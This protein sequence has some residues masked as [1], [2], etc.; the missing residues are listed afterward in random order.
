VARRDLLQALGPFDERLHIYG[1]DIDLCLR[2]HRAGAETLSAP[3]VAQVVHLGHRSAGRRYQDFGQRTKITT[4]GWVIREHF[5]GPAAAYDWLM[6]LAMQVTRLV[7]KTFLRH[8]AAFER[9]YIQAALTR[10]VA[11]RRRGQLASLD[12]VSEIADE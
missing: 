11:I 6:Q 5:G 2:A 12:D 1:E 8:N 4:R 10:P 7:V 3:D 9:S